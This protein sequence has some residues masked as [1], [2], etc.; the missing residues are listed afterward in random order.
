[1]P[2]RIVAAH[3]LPGFLLTE[4]Y[5]L[6]LSASAI[7]AHLSL[8]LI[9]FLQAGMYVLWVSRTISRGASCKCP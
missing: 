2:I 8:S 6:S 7:M 3:D 1:M 4:K 9:N 5:M